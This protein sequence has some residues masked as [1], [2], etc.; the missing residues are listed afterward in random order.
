VTSIICD[1]SGLL[2]F[3]DVAEA[4]NASVSDV[5]EAERGPFV[6]S[7]FVMAELDYLLASRRGTTAEVAVLTELTSGAWEHPT[8]DISDLRRARDLIGR[9]R[10]QEIGLTDAS[11]VVLAQRYQTNRILTLDH[12][13][14]DVVR[15]LGGASFELLP[16]R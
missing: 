13:H 14:F 7:P 16:H 1:T 4:H 2:A 5:V 12:R 6:V 11:L 10:D 9:Y 3:F 8:F 15:T